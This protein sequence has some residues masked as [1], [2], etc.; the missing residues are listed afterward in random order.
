MQKHH[1]IA[2]IGRQTHVVGHEDH[3]PALVGERLDDP[4]HLLLELGVERGSRLIEQQRLRLH[5]ER[6]GDGGALL[7]PA[8]KLRRPVPGLVADPDLVEQRAGPRLNLLGGLPEHRDRRLH[9]VL[10]HRHVRP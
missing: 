7:L 3:R 8:R 1:V 6:A 5:A 10:E 4:H 9:H 2:H